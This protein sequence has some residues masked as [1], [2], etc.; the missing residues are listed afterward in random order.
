MSPFDLSRKNKQFQKKE[1]QN[2]MKNDRVMPNKGRVPKWQLA[3]FRPNVG[4]F[5]H[6]FR[7]ID[8][9][10]VL[11]IIYIKIGE[12]TKYKVNWT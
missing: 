10:F 9:K 5:G 7:D 2:P 6:I 11:P 3:Y 4:Y 8:F 12:Q 1:R